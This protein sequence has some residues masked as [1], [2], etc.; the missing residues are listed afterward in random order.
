M[1]R[2]LVTGS[3]GYIGSVLTPYLQSA[4]FD[5]V[6]QDV[7]F[8]SGGTLYPP[9]DAPTLFRDSRDIAPAD[10][11][12]V[13]AVVHLAGISNDPMGKLDAASVYDPTRGYSARLAKMCK[14]RGIAFIFASSCSV[15][16]IGSDELLTETGPT[17]PQTG[18]SL[19]KLQIEEDLRALAG[20]AF[21]PIALRFA[22]IF[23]R[24]PRLRFDVVVNMLTGLAATTGKIVLNSDGQSWRPNLHILDACRAVRA[25][26]DLDYDGGDL[27]V[28]NVGR[29]DNNLQVL[30][31][32]KA[33]QR[34]VPGCELRFLS[35][36]PDLD[37]DG[38][39]KDRK[40]RDGGRDTRTY[41][42]SFEKIR[43]V[44]PQFSCEW[45]VE[46]GARDLVTLFEQIRLDT[47]TFKRREFYRL[48]QLEY[49]HGN[50]Y[51]SDALRWQT[52]PVSAP[53]RD[54]GLRQAADS[55][56]RRHPKI[57]HAAGDAW[58]RVFNFMMH[59][60]YMQPHHHPAAEK[61]ERIHLLQGRLAVLFFDDAGT[62]TDVI[63][64]EQGGR[65]FVEVPGFTWHTY[66]MLSDSAVTYE[67]MMGRY[68]PSTW[69]EFARWA[70]AEDSAESGAYLQ[71]LKEEAASRV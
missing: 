11:D 20:K 66:V 32:A 52:P 51:V 44:M 26:I 4:G 60:S 53:E 15:Y 56:R 36:S 31:I 69:K 55:R 39:I 35:E 47:A 25:A 30:D 17:H 65:E 3:L 22:T 34:V 8:F 45:T 12:G 40:V 23:G 37:R 59:D 2:V 68:E 49:L 28:L 46:E 43:Q 29:D 71:A 48:Q 38:L 6:G 57:L 5:C 41:K 54:E 24:S 58:N 27:L 63:V 14:D 61:I 70:P 1:K 62:V 67:T 64:L 9:A 21:S 50:G 7:G 16:G 10:L 19:N 18:Y 33:I 42:V 13:Q